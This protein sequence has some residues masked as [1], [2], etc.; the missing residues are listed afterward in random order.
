MKKIIIAFLL[1][2]SLVACSEK[3]ITTTV[4]EHD[5]ENIAKRVNTIVA[6][7]D[8][9]TEMVAEVY[10]VG[11]INENDVIETVSMIVELHEELALR[12]VTAG[13]EYSFDPETTEFWSKESVVIDNEYMTYM[14][15]VGM[16]SSDSKPSYFSLEAVVGSFENQGFTCTVE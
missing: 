8:I 16:L 13:Y 2:A 5:V 3:K 7:G 10:S 9:V 6:K 1:I 15:E 4:C 12:G 14:K 11:F